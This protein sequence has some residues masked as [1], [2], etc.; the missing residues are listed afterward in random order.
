MREKKRQKKKEKAGDANH[1]RSIFQ[2]KRSF[3]AYFV[4]VKYTVFNLTE[5]GTSSVVTNDALL[6]LGVTINLLSL[7][8]ND[9]HRSKQKVSK[10]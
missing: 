6:V 4:R 7:Q 2:N 8:L 10:S 5:F 9:T 3:L 1:I